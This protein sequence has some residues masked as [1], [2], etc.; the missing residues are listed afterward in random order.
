MPATPYVPVGFS[1]TATRL[2]F[3]SCDTQ[4]NVPKVRLTPGQAMV[5][6]SSSAAGAAPSIVFQP[7]I[8]MRPPTHKSSST[9]S[10]VD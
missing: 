10:T 1:F 3:L 6:Y 5:G 4:F 2:S 7:N 9:L 8:F